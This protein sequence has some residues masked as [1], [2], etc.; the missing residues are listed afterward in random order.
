M[1]STIVDFAIC[2]LQLR[3]GKNQK[4]GGKKRPYFSDLFFTVLNVVQ[5]VVRDFLIV[6]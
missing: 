6:I 3:V 1:R 2:E 5:S 4:H